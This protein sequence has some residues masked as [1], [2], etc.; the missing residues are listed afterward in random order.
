LTAA[1]T[2]TPQTATTREVTSGRQK[3]AQQQRRTH[4]PDVEVSSWSGRAREPHVELCVR[5]DDGE[6]GHVRHDAGLES[7]SGTGT[8]NSGIRSSIFM[9]AM[10][11]HLVC[12]PVAADDHGYL[13]ALPT[14]IVRQPDVLQ[15]V[16]HIL[17]V[18]GDS[19]CDR[20]QGSIKSMTVNA[21]TRLSFAHIIDLSMIAALTL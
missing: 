14:I 1:K 2:W 4:V 21:G 9:P 3:R 11:R 19:E 20:C 10:L 18:P 12:G 17:R 6:L 15:Y 7:G 5:C 16:R 13:C 8:V